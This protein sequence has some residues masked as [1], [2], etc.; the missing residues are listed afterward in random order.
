MVGHTTAALASADLSVAVFIMTST[1]ITSTIAASTAVG[2]PAASM[3]AG[4][5]AEAATVAPVM[6]VEARA[7]LAQSRMA[8]LHRQLPGRPMRGKSR[9]KRCW[10]RTRVSAREDEAMRLRELAAI[11][12]RNAR[13]AKSPVGREYLFKPRP[14]SKSALASLRKLF[15]DDDRPK[16]AHAPSRRPANLGSECFEAQNERITGL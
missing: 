3:R 15:R 16:G 7:D 14:V 5:L 8:S 11:A 12:R 9:R 10:A 2:T 4:T 13:W 6:A 1:I